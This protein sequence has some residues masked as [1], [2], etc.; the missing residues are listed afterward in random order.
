ME[1][2]E[3]QMQF[4]YCGLE[5]MLKLHWSV[6]CRIIIKNREFSQLTNYLLNQYISVIL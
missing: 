1:F 2:L 5:Q 4:F 3:I 6:S